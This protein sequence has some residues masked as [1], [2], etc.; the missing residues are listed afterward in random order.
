MLDRLGEAVFAGG[1]AEALLHDRLSERLE[2]GE[3]EATLHLD[4]PF[5][6]RGDVALKKI[7]LE[8]IVRVDGHKRTMLL[9][10]GLAD[11]RPAGASL[12]D[13]GLTVRFTTAPQAAEEAARV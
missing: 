9:P 4:L 1:Q 11:F 2:V 7:G 6:Q 3:D 12:R 8:L 5:V 10:P 13:G